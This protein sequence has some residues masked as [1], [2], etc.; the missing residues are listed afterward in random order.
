M[1]EEVGKRILFGGL[2]LTMC[3]VAKFSYRKTYEFVAE[4]QG[5]KIKEW[6]YISENKSKSLRIL[7]H[8]D[9]D[10]FVFSGKKIQ[11]YEFSN[12]LIFWVL[13]KNYF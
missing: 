3:F 11:N 10:I 7:E 6:K 1:S 13:K 9:E 12:I 8:E 5:V 4:N 2:V